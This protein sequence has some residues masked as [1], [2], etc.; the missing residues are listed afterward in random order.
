MSMAHSALHDMG[1]VFDL[2]EYKFT[3]KENIKRCIEMKVKN[4]PS[5]YL[6]GQLLYSSLIPN[7]NELIEAIRKVM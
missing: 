5:L 1:D 7:Q 2:V 6:N 3:V 4:L